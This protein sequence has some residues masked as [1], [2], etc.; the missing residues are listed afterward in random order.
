M[1]CF[2]LTV[3]GRT[4]LSAVNKSRLD[5]CRTAARRFTVKEARSLALRRRPTVGK[6]QREPQSYNRSPT[7]TR[8]AS[9]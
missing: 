1:V 7:P 8:I 5:Y 6:V 2:C 9:M 4:P 3:E